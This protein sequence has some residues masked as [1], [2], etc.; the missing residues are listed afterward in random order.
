MRAN[1]G[2]ARGEVSLPA[3]LW[4]SPGSERPHD[5]LAGGWD[6]EGDVAGLLDVLD[7]VR[8]EGHDVGAGGVAEAGVGVWRGDFLPPWVWRRGSRGGACRV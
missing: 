2:G 1:N 7:G 6:Q 5:D 4:T 3:T 8:T